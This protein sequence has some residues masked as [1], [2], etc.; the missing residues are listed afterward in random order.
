MSYPVGYFLEKLFAGLF[1]CCAALDIMRCTSETNCPS[2]AQGDSDAGS[3]APKDSENRL[4][5]VPR[6]VSGGPSSY[7]PRDVPF[8]ADRRPRNTAETPEQDFFPD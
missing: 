4:E 2:S 1:A 3:G 5:P 7:L 8:A 6:P